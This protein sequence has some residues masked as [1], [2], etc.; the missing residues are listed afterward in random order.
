MNYVNYV[1]CVNYVLGFMFNEDLS[2]VALI[3]KNKPTWQKGKL[4]GIGG[5]IE[6]DRVSLLEEMPVDAMVREFLEETGKKTLSTEWTQFA[7]MLGQEW[8][9]KCFVSIGNLLDLKTTTDEKIEIV[10]TKN[11]IALREQSVENII[12]LIYLAVDVLEDCRPYFVNVFYPP[13]DYDGTLLR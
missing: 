2:K 10:D 5:K 9:V 7:S 11:L 6:R 12:W 13:N 3:R 1:N 8:E 4:N